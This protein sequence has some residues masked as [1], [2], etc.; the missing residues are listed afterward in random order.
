MSDKSI[1]SELTDLIDELD[2]IINSHIE[3]A[4]TG[5]VGDVKSAWH[6]GIFHVLDKLKT[7]VDNH[8]E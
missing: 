7:I 8:K 3:S 1:T 6:A 5:I 2:G 4:E